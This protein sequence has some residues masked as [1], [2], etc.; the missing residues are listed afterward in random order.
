M[1]DRRIIATSPMA[2]CSKPVFHSVIIIPGKK[3]YSSHFFFICYKKHSS[4]GVGWGGGGDG[5]LKRILQFA[6]NFP[7]AL[8]SSATPPHLH[9]SQYETHQVPRLE[10]VHTLTLACTSPAREY[11]LLIPVGLHQKMKNTLLLTKEE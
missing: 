10:K 3:F 9:R 11:P 7:M 1:S 6:S 2:F 8:A 4:K 5:A